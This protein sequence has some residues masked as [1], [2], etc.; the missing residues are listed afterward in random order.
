MLVLKSIVISGINKNNFAPKHPKQNQLDKYCP[1]S[2][3]VIS[4]I[5]SAIVHRQDLSGIIFGFQ[6]GD[7]VIV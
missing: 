3:S 2:S 7:R 4:K 6:F 1:L 5:N